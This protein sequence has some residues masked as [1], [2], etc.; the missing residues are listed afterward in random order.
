MDVAIVLKTHDI[1]F[2]LGIYDVLLWCRQLHLRQEQKPVLH[3]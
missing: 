2:L 3:L 1:S